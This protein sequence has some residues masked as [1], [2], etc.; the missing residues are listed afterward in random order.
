MNPK[1]PWNQL[2]SREPQVVDVGVSALRIQSLGC[3]LHR[4]LQNFIS[5]FKASPDVATG[6]VSMKTGKASRA[7]QADRVMI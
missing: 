3:N 2:M 1:G 7:T 5:K 4:H 6:S